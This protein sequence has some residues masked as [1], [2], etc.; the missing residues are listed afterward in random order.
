LDCLRFGAED[1]GAVTKHKLTL[2]L[3]KKELYDD[4]N[5]STD[6]YGSIAPCGEPISGT[7]YAAPP[8]PSS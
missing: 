4:W 1:I 6:K 7:D 3:T 5:K 8:Q 2:P